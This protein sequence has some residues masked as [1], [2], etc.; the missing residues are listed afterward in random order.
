MLRIS[1]GKPSGRS[2]QADQQ[3]YTFSIESGAPESPEDI[4]KEMNK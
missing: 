3:F 4:Y 2:I 1:A